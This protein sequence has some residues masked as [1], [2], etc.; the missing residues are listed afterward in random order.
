MRERERESEDGKI[1]MERGMNE[2]VMGERG[3][4][5]ERGKLD[6]KRDR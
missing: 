6:T 5:G 3:R 1:T 2:R 4:E